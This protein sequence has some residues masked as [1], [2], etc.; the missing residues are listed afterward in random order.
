MPQD[1]CKRPLMKPRERAGHV[2]MA[3][4]APAGHSAPMPMPNNARKKKRNANVGE[5][6]AMKLHSEYHRID[7][8]SGAR[9]PIRSA[10]HPAVV[11]PSS[12]SHS[13]AVK[14]AVTATN[15]TPNS[16]EI[17]NMISRKMVKSNASSVQPSQAAIHAYH[18][19]LVGSRHHAMLSGRASAIVAIAIPSLRN[20]F[21][22][23]IGVESC[24]SWYGQHL[25]CLKS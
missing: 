4:A 15:G 13:V 18:W 20:T 2:S 11:A 17:G 3:S 5:K 6:P 12:R 21:L 24:L 22:P 14:T 25:L 8:I 19:S 23:V 10:I 16:C 7:I 1:P 9:R